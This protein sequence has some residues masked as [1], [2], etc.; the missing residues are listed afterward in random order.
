MK[1]A[2]IIKGAAVILAAVIAPGLA[3]SYALFPKKGELTGLERGGIS[4]LLGLVPVAFLY[5]LDK[6]L[7]VPM[8]SVTVSASILGF[9]LLGYA[10]F[11]ARSA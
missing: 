2:L 11:R 1:D 8:N 4:L 6:N 5:A 7:S 9:I 10:G 3:L